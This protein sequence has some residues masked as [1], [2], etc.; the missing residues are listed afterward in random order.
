M[1]KKIAALVIACSLL[2]VPNLVICDDWTGNLNVFLGAKLLD[3]HEWE[4]VEE[5]DEFGIKLDLKQQGWPVSIVIDYLSSS[6]D[7]TALM[8]DP[9]SGTVEFD[10]EGE[11]SELN[12][13]VRK[14]WD[15]FPHIR[16]FIGAGL[17]SISAE[18]TGTALGITVS[19]SDN[20]VGIWFGGGI[21]WTLADHFNIGLEAA[22]STAEVTLFDVNADAGGGHFGVL[23]GLHW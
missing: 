23:A 17:S 15:Q 22:F 11:T 3:E 21:Y 1:M 19:D 4:P 2:S 14:I 20:A 10:I 5:Q 8:F 16:P 18:Y 7:E 9:L 13:G 12:L 6:G